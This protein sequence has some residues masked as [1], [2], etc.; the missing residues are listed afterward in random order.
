MLPLAWR[1]VRR[2]PRRFAACAAAIGSSVVLVCV[3]AELYGGLLASV[4]AYPD[5]LPGDLIVAQAGRAAQMSHS[6]STVAAETDRAVRGV[7]GVARVEA[8]YG[9]LGWVERDGRQAIV[10]LVGLGPGDRF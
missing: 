5:S 3:A 4:S 6:S 10:F 2:H 7:P 8:L 9:H 1:H